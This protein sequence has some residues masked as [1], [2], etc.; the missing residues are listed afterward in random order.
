M[1]SF[2][3]HSMAKGQ[4]RTMHIPDT[5]FLLVE[6]FTINNKESIAKEIFLFPP[7][8]PESITST[9]VFAINFHTQEASTNRF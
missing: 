9:F 3:I 2:I 6:N 1:E 8:T 4:K 7:Q 5:S